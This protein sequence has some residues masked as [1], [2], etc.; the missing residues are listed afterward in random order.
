MNL[1]KVYTMRYDVHIFWISGAKNQFSYFSFS[2][3]FLQ[4]NVYCPR[5]RYYRK[6]NQKYN[7]DLAQIPQFW[8][9]YRQI[10]VHITKMKSPSAIILKTKTPHSSTCGSFFEGHQMNPG[11]RS[12]QATGEADTKNLGIFLFYST[13]LN[14]W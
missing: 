6:K 4:K 10:C 3:N 5:N 8:P 9:L 1:K 11:E 14:N 7:A 12:W 2:Y 13:I